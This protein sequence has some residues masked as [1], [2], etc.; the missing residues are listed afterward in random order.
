MNNYSEKELNIFNG[1]FKLALQ[2]VQLNRM[3]AQQIATAAGVGKGTIYDYFSSK[4]EIVAKALVY[5]LENATEQM[6][7]KL[8]AL[9]GFE[10]KML[11]LYNRII[12]NVDDS[13]SIYNTIVAMG[14]PE[15]VYSSFRKSENC[16]MRTGAL[17]GVINIFASVT[18]YGIKTGRITETDK[19]YIY[20]T[21]HANIYSVGKERTEKKISR[22]KI[23]ENAYKMLVKALN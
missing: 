21:V 20:M 16:Q 3:T 15:K 17:A 7:K 9:A 18:E 13:F 12:D 22:E 6:N 2:G 4:E 19:D 1:V 5:K 8:A 14:G 10:D 23:C 11:C